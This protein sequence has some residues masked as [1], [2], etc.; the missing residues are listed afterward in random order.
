MYKHTK[1]I[2]SISIG[3]LLLISAVSYG[4]QINDDLNISATGYLNAIEA[5]G[6]HFDTSKVGQTEASLN[7]SNVDGL[8]LSRAYLT[9]IDKITDELSGRLTLDQS[10]SDPSAPNG[11]GTIY[12]KNVSATYS[13]FAEVNLRMGIMDTP[14]IPWEEHYWPYRFLAMTPADYEGIQTS[15]DYGVALFG[16]IADKLIDYYIMGSNGEG[17]Q[18]TQDGRGYAGSA[19]ITLNVNPIILSVFGWDESMHNGIPDYNP[20]RAIAMLMYT[21]SLV[22]VAGEYF[23]ADDHVMPENLDFTKFDN[24]HGYSL[25]GFI[26]IPGEEK[27]RA[28]ARYLYTKPNSN[29]AY[30]PVSGKIEPDTDLGVVYETSLLSKLTSKENNWL[31]FGVSYDIAKDTIIAFDYNLYS[32]KGF[33]LSR[34][35]TTY[36]DSSIALNLQIGF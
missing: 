3:C 1:K 32:A 25:W 28:F 13:P 15:A 11:R 36:N 27:L 7:T 2:I 16:T 35:K 26:H 21:D 33:D 4:Y 20:K 34:N 9:V 24:G 6:N 8:W 5:S 18:A 19:R 12:V 29:D 23:W 14:W 17:Y 10:Y 22:R 31:L 30:K